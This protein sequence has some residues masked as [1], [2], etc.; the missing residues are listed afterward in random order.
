[1]RQRAIVLYSFRHLFL[2]AVST[3]GTNEA[4]DGHAL[5]GRATCALQGRRVSLRL[6][7]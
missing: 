5:E 7:R 4:R 1:V 2:P 6:L 3:N